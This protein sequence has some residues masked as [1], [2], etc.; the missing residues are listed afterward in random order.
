[1]GVSVA[2][3]STRQAG[4]LVMHLVYLCNFDLLY[5]G[6]DSI[7]LYKLQ[8]YSKNL[9]FLQGASNV[10]KIL[11][12]SLKPHGSAWIAR[13]AFLYLEEEFYLVANSDVLSS[14]DQGTLAKILQSDFIQVTCTV[15]IRI[16][17]Q[18]G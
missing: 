3:R 4:L 14:L 9:I 7:R 6:V 10:I 15:G 1:M 11:Q 17:E 2:Q 8:Y 13:Q 5:F 16:T 18:L 12:W